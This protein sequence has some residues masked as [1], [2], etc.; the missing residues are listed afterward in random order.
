MS[1]LEIAYLLLTLLVAIVVAIWVLS[2]RFTQ[3]RRAQQRGDKRAR[4]AWKPFWMS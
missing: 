4:Q 3:Y 1:R 2:L